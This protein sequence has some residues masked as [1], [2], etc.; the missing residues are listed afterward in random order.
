M[1]NLISFS[2]PPR[3]KLQL[4]ASFGDMILIALFMTLRRAHEGAHCLRTTAPSMQK[5]NATTK[6]RS[7]SGTFPV[8]RSPNRNKRFIS[9]TKISAKSEAYA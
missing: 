8:N 2:C 3:E 5:S 7:A 9:Q 4:S 6:H 1:S